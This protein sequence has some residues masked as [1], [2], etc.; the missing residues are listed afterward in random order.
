MLLKKVS[1]NY[2]IRYDIS[3]YSLLCRSLGELLVPTCT[4]VRFLGRCHKEALCNKPV[5]PLDVCCPICG[6][7]MAVGKGVERRK[8]LKGKGGIAPLQE[9]CG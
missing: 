3:E 1:P 8:I 4:A 7:Y 5:L 6:K 9:F 2:I